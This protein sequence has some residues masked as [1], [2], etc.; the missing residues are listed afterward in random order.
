MRLPIRIQRRRA[1]G[2]KMPAHT[3]YV[4]RGS[5]YGNPF[6]VA[7]SP[8]ELLKDI[9]GVKEFQER[10]LV[11]AVRLTRENAEAIAR[12]ARKRCGFTPDGRVMLVE[13][14]YT[15]WALEGDMIVARPG[16]MRLS[17]RI[18][19]DFTAWYTKPGEQLSEEDLG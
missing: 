15:I 2:W 4:G 6:W 1:R 13:H 12:G 8:F 9:P 14:T 10:A 17:N 19:E 5:L 18:P 16:S 7:R 3:K 11:R